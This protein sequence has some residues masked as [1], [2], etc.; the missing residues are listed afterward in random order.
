MRAQ[1]E[2][3]LRPLSVGEIFDRAVTLFVRNI[4]AFSTLYALISLPLIIAQVALGSQASSIP[5]YI[6]AIAHPAAA[7][8]GRTWPVVTEVFFFVSALFL[9]VTLPL[10]F[11]CA[12]CCVADIQR[13]GRTNW[14]PAFIHALKRLPNIWIALLLGLAALF[15]GA[16]VGVIA[17]GLSGLAAALAANAVAGAL[18]EGV[19]AA[20]FGALYL[21]WCAVLALIPTMAIYVTTIEE[22]NPFRALS[23]ALARLFSRAQFS[24]A[25][26]MALAGAALYAGNLAVA[27]GLAALSLTLAHSTIPAVMVN[28]CI[29]ILYTGFLSAVMAVYYFD[30]RLRN[31]GYDL[32]A[33]ID[34]LRSTQSA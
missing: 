30:T 32:Q 25:L 21:V 4:W 13:H 20:M 14:K 33:E 12:G 19:I 28:A 9:F 8:V 29:G 22:G 2:L 24:R 23:I 15:A 6:D 11:A 27:A 7:H 26:Q 1:S 16:F 3:D 5:Q 31:Q 18:G 17:I 34:R 10:V